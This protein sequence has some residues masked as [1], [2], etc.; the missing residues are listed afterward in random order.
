M[1][2]TR[3]GATPLF[4]VG[5]APTYHKGGPS[6][7]IMCGDTS[8]PH[9][10]IS[11][12]VGPT[13]L[14]PLV[15]T[16]DG[17]GTDCCHGNAQWRRRSSQLHLVAAL[18]SLTAS[19]TTTSV[20]GSTPTTDWRCLGSLAIVASSSGNRALMSGRAPIISSFYDDLT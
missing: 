12:D 3:M 2:P 11:L 1:G 19:I 6:P 15:P 20:A 4:E 13:S 9:L 10:Q 14:V 18:S 17:G 16:A 8:R 7:K 5:W